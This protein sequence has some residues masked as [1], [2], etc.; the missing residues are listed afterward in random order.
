MSSNQVNDWI[1]S[2]SYGALMLLP[3]GLKQTRLTKLFVMDLNGEYRDDEGSVFFAKPF[4]ELP[5]QDVITSRS[6][7]A[8]WVR[9]AVDQIRRGEMKK[10]VLSRYIEMHHGENFDRLQLINDMSIRYPSA[11]V[12]YI[13]HHEHGEWIGATPELLLSLANNLCTTYALAGTQKTQPDVHPVWNDKLKEEQQL[14]TD[15]ILEALTAIHVDQIEIDG[16]HDHEAGPLVHL[17]SVIQF[18][19]KENILDVAEVLHPT[20]AVCGMPR[21]NAYDFILKHE[22]HQRGL[23]TGYFGFTTHDGNGEIYVALRCMKI[24]TNVFG[25]YVGGGI[26]ALSDPDEEWTETEN[27]S[28]VMLDLLE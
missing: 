17:R 1:R 2:G 10:V 22:T 28:R 24:K 13:R 20:S 6:E 25:I 11:C 19:T 5:K 26:T 27:K 21:K 14:V 15:F 8:Q 4:S 12:F 18:E 3:L 23:Y 16:P 9:K 7:H